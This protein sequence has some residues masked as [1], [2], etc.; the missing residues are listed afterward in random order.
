MYS[1]DDDIAA[2]A[3]RL[4]VED[5]LDYGQ[6]KRQALH[7]LG[8]PSRTRLPD[9]DRVEAAVRE[10]IA[11]FCADTQPNELLALRQLAAE[12]MARLRPLR[13]YLAGAVWHGTATRLSDVFLQLFCDDA[14][15]AELWLINHGQ[16]YE[17]GTTRG[18]KG[19]NVDVLSFSS[20][21]PAMAENIGI[22]LSVYDLDDLK[23]A[24]K[25]DNQGRKPRGDEAAV[26]RLLSATHCAES[27]QPAEVGALHG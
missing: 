9:N 24:L 5:G 2:A 27:G 20:Y 26:Q 12:W 3:A 14:K 22:H 4:V 23:G 1:S 13:P 11:V 6:A 18:F 10:H 21:S 8:L 16:R 25:P 17:V 7:V 19:E 15:S